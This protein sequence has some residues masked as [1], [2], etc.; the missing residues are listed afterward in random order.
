MRAEMRA[1]L[2]TVMAEAA[3]ATETVEMERDDLCKERDAFIEENEMLRTAQQ[4][5]AGE[6]DDLAEE[7]D[8]LARARDALAEERDALRREVGEE[9]S[10][11]AEA[12]AR[13][14]EL[15]EM[16]Q[17]RDMVIATLAGAVDEGTRNRVLAMLERSVSASA[18]TTGPEAARVPLPPPPPVAAPAVAASVAAPAPPPQEAPSPPRRVRVSRHGSIDIG[19]GSAASIAAAKYGAASAAAAGAPPSPPRSK[20]ATTAPFGAWPAPP[21]A[22]QA[23]ASTAEESGTWYYRAGF[24]WARPLAPRESPDIDAPKMATRLASGFPNTLFTIDRR[25][26]KVVDGLRIGFLRL[27]DG[28]GWLFD[29]QPTNGTKLLVEATTTN[30]A[31]PPPRGDDDG[32][33]ARRGTYFGTYAPEE[34]AT[35]RG[36]G[37]TNSTFAGMAAEQPPHAASLAEVAGAPPPRPLRS[38][39]DLATRL[40]RRVGGSARAAA[41]AAVAAAAAHAPPRVAMS[42]WLALR[43]G[44]EWAQ[45]WFVAQGG[46]LKCFL[47]AGLSDTTPAASAE[48]RGMKLRVADAG[49]ALHFAIAASGGVRWLMRASS[50]D[51]RAQWTAALG[52]E[53]VPAPPA[54]AAA[55]QPPTAAVAGVLGRS[56]RGRA[57]AAGVGGTGGSSRMMAMTKSARARHANSQRRGKEVDSSSH[58]GFGASPRFAK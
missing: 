18:K 37:R 43:V 41:A 32:G 50:A 44:E 14:E 38:T 55:F 12:A 40:V 47:N 51:V 35:L 45:R 10:M 57:A 2:R 6:R 13:V 58:K 25:V 23:S 56:A 34:V 15:V 46:Q 53:S 28:R 20:P 4:A 39:P 7:R 30:A 36:S 27:T 19:D 21:A 16:L 8:A 17:T 24:Y 11:R 49:D 29:T 9:A 48:L 26:F 42:G 52:G 33:S 1:E 31:P 5:L 3:N 22:A 54:A